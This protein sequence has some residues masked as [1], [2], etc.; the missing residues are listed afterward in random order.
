[1]KITKFWGYRLNIKKKK[2]KLIIYSSQRLVLNLTKFF[3][4]I[5]SYNL[6]LRINNKNL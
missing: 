2:I 6:S 3:A 4:K 1:M 5:K